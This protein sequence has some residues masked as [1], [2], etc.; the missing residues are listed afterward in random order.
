MK[1]MLVVFSMNI[2]TYDS[3]T[4]STYSSRSFATLCN[5]SGNVP[6]GGFPVREPV[7]SALY[8]GDLSTFSPA[9]FSLIFV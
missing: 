4:L 2:L 6:S 7:G 8:L 1:S 9:Y 3:L 5:V